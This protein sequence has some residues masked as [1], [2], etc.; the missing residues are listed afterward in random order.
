VLVGCSQGGRIA[1]DATL[2]RPAR[3]SGLV[4]VCAAMSGE[5]PAPP[6]LSALAQARLDAA[7]AA[8]AGA[9]LVALN[10][11]EAQL[12]L[13]GPEQPAGRVTGP[14]RARFLDMNGIALGAAPV[15]TVRAAPSAYARLEQVAV[16][17]LVVA[18]GLDFADITALMREAASRIPGAELSVF[19]D[20]AHLPNL[21]Q[22]EL[23]A[24]LLA[25]FIARRTL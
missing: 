23:F 18:G 8:E 25:E 20:A 24:A 10:A 19:A 16:P 7:E 6:P 12:W 5:R 11:A 22:P 2:E 21:E 14:A 17:T 9:D 15:G 1:L 4:L 3:V 13:D